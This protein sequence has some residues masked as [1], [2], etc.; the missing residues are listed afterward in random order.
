MIRFNW[1]INLKFIQAANKLDIRWQQTPYGSMESMCS[2]CPVANR[3]VSFLSYDWGSIWEWQT[4]STQCRHYAVATNSICVADKPDM[5][6]TRACVQVVQL[7]TVMWVCSAMIE[8]L[9]ETDEL[10]KVVANKLNMDH[11]RACV[12]GHW[13]FSIISGDDSLHVCMLMRLLVTLSDPLLS[14][15]LLASKWSFILNIS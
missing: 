4:K 10:P 15:S 14:I 6:Q 7:P 11:S 8:V 12:N 1:C 9:Y 5:D 2:S 13:V 3:D